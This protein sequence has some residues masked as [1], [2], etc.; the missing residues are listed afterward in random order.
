MKQ[1]GIFCLE[2]K[3]YDDLRKRSTVRPILELLE[4]NS[5]IPYIHAD[6]A[7]KTEF[8]F[9]LKKWSLKKYARYPILYLAFHGSENG[10]WISNEFI[11]LDEIS[12]KVQNKCHNRII[13]FASCSTIN[14]APKHLKDFLK[15]TG[16]L[17]ICGYKLIVPWIQSTALELMILSTM[18]E[19]AFDGRGLKAIKHKLETVSEMFGTLEFSIITQ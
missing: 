6:C 5:D 1:K 11:T 3:W 7:T 15:N 19:N 18:Q 2:A 17:A 14:I 12:R 13:L 8:E 10:I 9:F 16:A 4:M